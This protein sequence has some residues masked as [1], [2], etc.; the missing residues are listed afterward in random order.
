MLSGPASDLQGTGADDDG[1]DTDT[2]GVTKDEDG[3]K[4]TSKSKPFSKSKATAGGRSA[5]KDE[6]GSSSAS[7]KSNSGKGK[8]DTTEDDGAGRSEGGVK[9]WVLLIGESIA[10]IVVGGLLFKGF[11]KLWDMM[12]W[13]AFG[14]ALLVIVGLVA[15]VRV[16]RRTDDITSQLIAVGVGAFVAFGPLLFLLPNR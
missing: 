10:A 2:I 1:D 11:E 6:A 16:L 7:S 3:G 5:S 9:Q 8:P 13:V 12:P 4:G 14:L 15:L